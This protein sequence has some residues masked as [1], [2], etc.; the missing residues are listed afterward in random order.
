MRPAVFI[1]LSLCFPGHAG[2]YKAE[3]D[4]ARIYISYKYQDGDIVQALV[5]QLEAKGHDVQYDR[6]LFIGAAWRSQLAE[7]LLASDILLVLW[8]KKT[9]ESQFVPAEVGIARVTPSLGLLPVVI[10]REDEVEIPRFIN[11]LRVERIP[12]TAPE[13]LKTLVEKLDDSIR[14][15]IAYRDRRKPGRP[16]I[17]ISH[18]HKDEAI[19]RALTECFEACFQIGR[20]DIRCTSV[21]P[22]RLPVGEDTDDRLRD[23]IAAAEAVL[24]IL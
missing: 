5:P 13:T 21:R 12:D 17:F 3:D 14:K 16:R 18:R 10:G 6:D 4:M 23:E 15:Q 19:V 24:G 22:Y 1:F 7:A 20:E 9:W 11:D 2:I 8:T